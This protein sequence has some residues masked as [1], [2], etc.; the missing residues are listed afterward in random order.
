MSEKIHRY[1][2]QSGLRSMLAR[3]EHRGIDLLNQKPGAAS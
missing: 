1:Q 2:E 3:L